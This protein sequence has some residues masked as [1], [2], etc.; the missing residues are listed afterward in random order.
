[1]RRFSIGCILV[2]IAVLLVT[3]LR[4]GESAKLPRD[5]NCFYDDEEGRAKLLPGGGR[6]RKV[7]KVKL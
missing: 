2:T 7:F 4:C 6:V 1:M 3:Y 5:S